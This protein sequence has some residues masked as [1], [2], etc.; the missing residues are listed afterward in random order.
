MVASSDNSAV[1]SGR[2]ARVLIADDHAIN[3][4]L[5]RR[6]L[7]ALGYSVDEAET[8]REALQA[9]ERQ[10]YD[11]ILMDCHMPEMDGFEATQAVRRTDGPNRYTPIV[12]VTATIESHVREACL[13]AGMDDFASK[14]VSS[15]ELLSLLK[16]W[17]EPPASPALD[18][19][20]V[21]ILRKTAAGLIGELIGLYMEDAPVRMRTIRDAVERRDASALAASSHALR[22]SSGN[23]GAMRVAEICAKLETM[24]REGTTEGAPAMVEELMNEYGCA[25]RA[26]R[27]LR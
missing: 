5:A 15:R 19:A 10:K 12:A 25:M 26:L 11:L 6:Q 1:A 9:M 21:E 7:L 14:P 3:R 2:P 23:V 24:G 22:S 4:L 20:K 13:A 27:D 16:R 17:I 8:G 18:D